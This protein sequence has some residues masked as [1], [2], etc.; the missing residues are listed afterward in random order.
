M[1][2]RLGYISVVALLAAVLIVS[3]SMAVTIGTVPISIQEVY[4]VIGHKLLGI[5]A[6]DIFGKGAIHDVVWLIRLPRLMLAAVVGCGLAVCGVIMQA[7]VKNPLADPYVLGVSSGASL[8]ATFA[9]MLGVGTVFGANAIGICAF[10]G[11]FGSAILVMIVANIGGR[12][13]AVKLLLAG[14]A[15]GAICSSFSSFIIYLANDKEGMQTLTFWMMGSL[16]GAKWEMLGI[17]YFVV[18]GGILFLWTQSR[19]LNLM[20]LGDDVAITLG[21][22]LHRRRQIYLVIVALMIG[23]IV[24]AAGMIGFVGLIVPHVVRMLFGTN[25][26]KM[27]PLAALVGA[28]F[29]VWADVL[30]RVII[31]HSELPVGILTSMIG[32]PCFIYLMIR[33]K[34]GFGGEGTS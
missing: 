16:A 6:A 14:M 15:L 19:T 28:I 33:K 30:C 31:P 32:A 2:K 23:F 12:A 21:T 4:G 26:K 1:N 17:I 25:H 10:I 34:Y 9:I 8:G 24:Y 3:I 27:I 29:L 20:L 22:D 5:G 7:I 18:M 13:N 11:A